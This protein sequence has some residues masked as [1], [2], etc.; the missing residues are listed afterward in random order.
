MERQIALEILLK[1]KQDKSYLN[2]TINAYFNR[3]DLTRQ[4]KDFITR[5]VYGTVQNMLLLEYI[6]KPHLHMRVKIYEKMLLLMSLYQ[7]E[8]MDSIPDYAIINEAVELS[9]KKKGMKTARFIHAIL[10]KTFQSSYQLDDLPPLERISIATSHP[11]WLVKMFDKQY[12]YEETNRICHAFLE[13]PHHCARVNTLLTSKE[14]LLKDSKWQEAKLSPD[15]LYYS[16]HH[17][18][19]DEAFIKGYVTIQDE[20]SQLVARLLNP[21]ASD[22]VLDMCCAP[23]SKTTHLAM[24]MNNQGSIEAYDLYA[25]KIDLVQQQ[26]QRLKVKNVHTH[27]G[28]STLLKDVY[29]SESFDKILCDAPCSGLGVLA[30]KPE[31]KY[32][33]SSAMDEMIAIQEKLLENAYFLLKKGGNIVYSTCTLNKKE[34]EKQIEKFMTKYPDMKK[35][36]ELTILPYQ[37]HSDGFYMCLLEKE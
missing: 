4:Q 31:I 16:G 32:H 3:Y 20:S 8:M 26:I 29:P 11:L 33:E 37:Y 13:V 9:K 34:N 5:V 2:L 12:G 22:Y 21:Q 25:H 14:A 19:S 35:R 24:L 27:V 10:Q 1:F 6:L 36:K 30:R 28:D 18:A 15:G 7:H 17:I 23:G